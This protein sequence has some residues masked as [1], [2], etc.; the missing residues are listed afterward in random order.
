MVTLLLLATQ[1]IQ[2]EELDAKS[3]MNHVRLALGQQQ[4]IVDH[5]ILGILILHINVILTL[6]PHRLIA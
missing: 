6:E 2:L 4:E 5:V 1:G 3:A